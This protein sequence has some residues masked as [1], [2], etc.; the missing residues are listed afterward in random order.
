MFFSVPSR[1]TSEGS[2]R[3]SSASAFLR[4]GTFGWRIPGLPPP[5]LELLPRYP[6]TA[7]VGL[8]ALCVTLAWWNEWDL[9]PLFMDVRAWHGQPWR[10]VT[11]ALPHIDIL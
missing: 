6:V 9:D 2:Q 1:P 3:R 11:S 10:L 7:G 4:V 8:A 5:S